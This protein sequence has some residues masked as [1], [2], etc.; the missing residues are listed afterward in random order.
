MSPSIN[1]LDVLT[2]EHAVINGTLPA[3]STSGAAVSSYSLARRHQSHPAT[4]CAAAL[5]T[6]PTVENE[7]ESAS[8]SA[9][10]IHSASSRTRLPVPPSRVDSPHHLP[11]TQSP[12]A[13][14]E[15][16]NAQSLSRQTRQAMG[17]ANAGNTVC[18]PSDLSVSAGVVPENVLS[19]IIHTMDAFSTLT[20]ADLTMYQ[21]VTST[22]WSHA[23]HSPT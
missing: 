12:S 8:S 7:V 21:T 13:A 5:P 1:I 10:V 18:V 4:E 9:H 20:V 22:S 23:I 6:N 3:H 15:P 16:E 19:L 11:H 17:T 2:P 14:V